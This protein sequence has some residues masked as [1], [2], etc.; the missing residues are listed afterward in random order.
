MAKP[1]LCGD[2]CGVFGCSGG[3]QPRGFPGVS[4]DGLAQGGDDVG[5]VFAGG[6]DVSAN[7]ESVLGDVFAGQP[8]GDFL[9]GLGGPQ[10]A[11]ADVVR[12]PDPGVEAEPENVVFVVTAELQQLPPG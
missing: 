7:V 9:L 3:S 4:G 8:A 10:V 1:L 5:A 6:V 12:G 11:L 2:V